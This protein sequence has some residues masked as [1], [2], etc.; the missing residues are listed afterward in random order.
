M[1]FVESKIS[2]KQHGFLSGKSCLSN[3]LE[4]VDSINDMLA[5]GE[6]VD[7]FFLD[8]QKAFDSVPHHRLLVKLQ[9]LGIHGK[10]L[11]VI[12]DFLSGRSFNVNVGNAR[13]NT[14]Q[15]KSGVPQG[16][17]LGPLL[18]LLYINDLPETIKVK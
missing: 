12:A 18:F 1:K 11:E 17:V 5:E 14:H 3:L 10:P 4:A 6:D 7:I 15:V 16:S 8:F 13:S 9:N 2:P